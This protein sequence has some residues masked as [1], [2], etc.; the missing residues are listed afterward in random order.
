MATKKKAPSTDAAP[1]AAATPTRKFPAG[2]RKKKADAPVQP[3]VPVA[4]AA[5][6]GETDAP[7]GPSDEAIRARA[8]AIWRMYGGS[9]MQNWL[10]AEAELREEAAKG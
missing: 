10:R 9:P 7:P 2:A 8:W 6:S 3:E 5:P 1:P 4:E